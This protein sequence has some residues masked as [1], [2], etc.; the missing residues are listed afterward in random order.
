MSAPA[1]LLPPFTVREPSRTNLLGV[2]QICITRDM[3]KLPG[4]QAA[5]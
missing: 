1:M 5:S 4:L 2:R 3:P